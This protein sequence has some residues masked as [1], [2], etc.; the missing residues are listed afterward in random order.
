MEDSCTRRVRL[1]IAGREGAR[2]GTV[3][4]RAGFAPKAVLVLELVVFED[5]VER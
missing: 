3:V 5:V 4:E 2:R 1:Y